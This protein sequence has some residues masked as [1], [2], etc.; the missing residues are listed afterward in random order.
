MYAPIILQVKICTFFCW[1]YIIIEIITVNQKV[2][3]FFLYLISDLHK[4]VHNDCTI[5]GQRNVWNTFSCISGICIIL[6]TLNVCTY[7]FCIKRDRSKYSFAF[8]YCIH[9]M[10]SQFYII[11]EYLEYYRTPVSLFAFSSLTCM[12]GQNCG[13]SY[14][15]IKQ[16]MKRFEIEQK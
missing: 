16:E 12:L 11:V 9:Q 10:T 2:H 3:T 5:N 1:L 7:V 14:M 4:Y 15:N 13:D 8:Y 6:N